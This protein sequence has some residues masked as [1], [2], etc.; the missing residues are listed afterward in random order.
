MRQTTTLRDSLHAL[1][2]WPGRQGRV[3]LTFLPPRRSSRCCV[4]PCCLC[5]R[6]DAKRTGSSASVH[7]ELRVQN[8]AWADVVDAIHRPSPAGWTR[9]FPPTCAFLPWA[10][11]S[12]AR[13]YRMIRR[14]VCV[15]VCL[16]IST[17]CQTGREGQ[18]S[19]LQLSTTREWGTGRGPTPPTHPLLDPPSPGSLSGWAKFF[20]GPSG[21]QKFS[22]APLAPV[23]LVL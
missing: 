23:S 22:L 5:N 14:R 3:T 8:G 17:Y 16:H 20:S 19:F 12:H 21:N 13:A 2:A 4:W 7:T 15:C 18:G 11:R 10:S 1:S 9:L 6:R